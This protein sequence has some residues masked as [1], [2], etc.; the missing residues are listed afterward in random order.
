M[1]RGRYLSRAYVPDLTRKRTG[2]SVKEAACLVVRLT[3]NLT[4]VRPL[5]TPTSHQR[6][7]WGPDS[8]LLVS[9]GRTDSRGS[10]RTLTSA[11]PALL[12]SNKPSEYR[13]FCD[14]CR[15]P[16]PMHLLSPGSDTPTPPGS[17][18]RTLVDGPPSALGNVPRPRRGMKERS[19]LREQRL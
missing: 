16:Q 4:S 7:T 19:W 17:R 11:D 14:N 2:R 15:I 13:N 6:P 3:S 10:Y 9:S 1:G 18:Y 8:R 12:L 5:P